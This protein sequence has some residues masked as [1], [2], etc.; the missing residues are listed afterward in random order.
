MGV[1]RGGK[2]WKEEKTDV[3][4]I[5]KER[6]SFCDR[7]ACGLI[8]REE[9]PSHNRTEK[10]DRHVWSTPWHFSNTTQKLLLPASI[11]LRPQ[12]VAGQHR[13]SKTINI[14]AVQHAHQDHFFFFFKV[15]VKGKVRQERSNEEMKRRRSAPE[16]VDL[17]SVCSECCYSCIW[18]SRTQVTWRRVIWSGREDSAEG[19]GLHKFPAAHPSSLFWS[20]NTII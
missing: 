3:R 5:I 8:K 1:F 9:T 2:R 11:F 18:F 10:W 14:P 6:W 13:I 17:S 7:L 19:K 15:S 4:W 20:V 12:A 16:K